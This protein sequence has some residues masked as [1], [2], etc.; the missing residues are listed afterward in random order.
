MAGP[1]QAQETAASV[2]RSRHVSTHRISKFRTPRYKGSN[3]TTS[4]MPVHRSGAGTEIA[5]IRTRNMDVKS[6]YRGAQAPDDFAGTR[7]L[8]RNR[9]L[10]VLVLANRKQH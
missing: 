2:A 8:A 3:L 9:D 1:W 4:W 6:L 7:C 10:T 5:S